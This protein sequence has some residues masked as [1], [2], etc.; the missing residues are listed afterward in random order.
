MT[1]LKNGRAP[2]LSRKRLLGPTLAKARSGLVPVVPAAGVKTGSVLGIVQESKTINTCP[3]SQALT[4]RTVII[5]TPISMT[6]V[7]IASIKTGVRKPWEIQGSQL[8]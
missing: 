3:A 8:R 1:G 2:L 6:T 5:V 7:E 4:V